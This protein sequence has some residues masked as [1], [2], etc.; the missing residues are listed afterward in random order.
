MRK[1]GLKI[2]VTVLFLCAALAGR[3]HAAPEVAVPQAV[4]D[5]GKTLEGSTVVHTFAIK[6]NGDS[7]LE[8]LDVKPDC[9]CTS[10]EFDRVIAPGKE[11][12]ITLTLDTAGFPGDIK[13]HT[14]VFTNDPQ[15]KMVVLTLGARV[16]TPI[17]VSQRYVIFKGE[18]GETLSRTLELQA[19][20]ERPLELEETFF[21]LGEKVTYRI[22]EVEKG[23]R[24]RIHFEN[25]PGPAERYHG[26]LKL[27]TNY[28][29]MPEIPIRIRARFK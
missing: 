10:A 5:A 22:E 23:S 7:P 29:E 28:P 6:N 8:I 11:G 15:R 19:G 13:K 24:F 25:V 2:L 12:G 26:L 18:A 14:R 21:D 3:V 4:F 20:L 27:G 1:T 9:G 16:W 17:S